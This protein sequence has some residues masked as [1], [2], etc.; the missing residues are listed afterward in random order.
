[1][2]IPH[3]SLRDTETSSASGTN[4][5]ELFQISYAKIILVNEE[6]WAAM[7]CDQHPGSSD[8]E[9]LLPSATKRRTGKAECGYK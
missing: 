7:Y 8:K 2:P 4:I 6:S 9:G 3:K 1:M 5:K